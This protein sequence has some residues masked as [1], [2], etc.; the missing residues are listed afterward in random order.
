MD[1]IVITKLTFPENVRQ[2][3]GMYLGTTENFSVPLREIINNSTD[4]LINN[5]ASWVYIVNEDNQ[6][7][8]IDNGRGLPIYEDKDM[9]DHTIAEAAVGS[10][11]AG[12]KL[13][14]SLEMT[15]GTHGLGAAATNAVSK[16]FILAVRLTK[17]IA[18]TSTDFV[19]SKFDSNKNQCYVLHYSCGY[20]KEELVI[21]ISELAKLLNY[22]IPVDFSTLVAIEPDTTLYSSG[23]SKIDVLPLKITATDFPNSKIVINGKQV[24]KFNFNRDVAKGSELFLNQSINFEFNYRDKIKFNGTIAFDKNSMQYSHTSLVNLIETTQG[25]YLESRLTWSLGYALTTFN[26]ALVVPDAKLGLILFNNVFTNYRLAFSSQTKEKLIRLG[27]N[28]ENQVRDALKAS[29]M[30][31]K[32]IDAEMYQHICNDPELRRF[33]TAEFTTLINKNKTYF[34]ALIEKIIEYKRQ[35]NKLSNKDFIKSHLI[36]GNDSDKRRNSTVAAKV[37]EATSR[38]Y[39][40]R[41]LYVTEGLS[42]SGSLIQLRNNQYQSIL[43]LRGKVLNSTNMDTVDVINSSELLALVNTI[44]CGIGELTDVSQSRYGKIII[45]TDSDADGSHI[46]NLIVAM[47]LTH[48]PEMIKAG[49]IYKLTP[50]FYAVRDPKGNMSY[51]DLT[52]KDKINFSHHVE[53]RKGLGSYTKE[54]VKKFMINPETRKLIKIN[55]DDIEDDVK[56]ATSLLY[57]SSARRNLMIKKG[58]LNG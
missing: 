24:E 8:V 38:N 41:E 28:S 42:A 33:L 14:E 19:K 26:N 54:E 12:S 13:G 10:L 39:E 44:G 17:S 46:A 15:V 20:L 27:G 1:D 47:F 58:V 6:K 2:N 4:E 18:L 31:D 43:P 23:K 16:N 49:K 30:L 25:G 55:Y 57:S 51:Y 11:H 5:H 36:L 9:P 29:G 21:E 53:K 7:I 3:I 34:N 52:E 37:Y 35:L 45:A 50:P 48:C 40:M 22:E 32:D 56:E